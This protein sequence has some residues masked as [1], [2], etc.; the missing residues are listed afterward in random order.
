M[1]PLSDGVLRK[2][3]RIGWVST[4]DGVYVTHPARSSPFAVVK[5]SSTG[6]S[7]WNLL[8]EHVRV[9]DLIEAVAAHWGLPAS[10]IS[11]DVTAFLE[12][13]VDQGILHRHDV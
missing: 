12:S 1:A 13:L 4:P 8:D 2:D 7:V 10:E 9:P 3:A 5:L 11:S 6:S